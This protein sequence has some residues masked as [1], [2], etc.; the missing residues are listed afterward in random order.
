MLTTREAGMQSLLLCAFLFVSF[1][2]ALD[3]HTRERE[4]ERERVK[5]AATAVVVNK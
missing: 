2:H 5:T 3:R 4:R 1:V